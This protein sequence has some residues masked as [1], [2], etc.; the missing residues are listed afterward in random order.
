[1]HKNRDFGHTTLEEHFLR[2]DLQGNWTLWGIKS[3]IIS[4]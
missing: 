1:M 4:R 2:M 3:P